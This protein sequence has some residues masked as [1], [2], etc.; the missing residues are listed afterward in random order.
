MSYGTNDMLELCIDLLVGDTVLPEHF[1]IEGKLKDGKWCNCPY[2][3]DFKLTEHFDKHPISLPPGI[4]EIGNYL[5]QLGIIFPEEKGETVVIFIPANMSLYE[6]NF[7][8]I[9]RIQI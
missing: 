4:S 8:G 7:C 2:A 5:K 3:L 6:R 1:C 9:F